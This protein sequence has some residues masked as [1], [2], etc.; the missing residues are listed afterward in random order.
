MRVASF[1]PIRMPI[2][3]AFAT[4]CPISCT[5]VDAGGVAPENHANLFGKSHASAQQCG[6]VLGAEI[7]GLSWARADFKPKLAIRL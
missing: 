5:E 1:Q 7:T 2:R 3:R 6:D 4:V